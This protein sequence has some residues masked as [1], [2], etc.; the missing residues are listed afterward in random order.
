IPGGQPGLAARVTRM[1][2]V[3]PLLADPELALVRNFGVVAH[4]DAGKTTLC[5]RM[6]V[7]TGVESRLGEVEEG[8]AVL[9][10]M[11]EERERGISITA[12]ATTLPWREH[13]LHLIDTPGHVDF[14]L[15]VERSLRVLDGAIVVFDVL[16]G[17]Q[18]QSEAVWRQMRRHHAAAVAFVNKLDRPG[19]DFLAA[20]RGI[21]ERLGVRC[22]PV[23]YPGFVDGKLVL[24]AD[25]VRGFAYV[26]HRAG[27]TPERIALP[28]AIAAEVGVL[29]A[30]LAEMLA[31]EDEQVFQCV[32]SDREPAAELLIAALR[33][34]T[35]EGSLL[36][37]ACGS[38]LHGIGVDAALDLV[39]D[40]LP[41]PVDRPPVRA[42]TVT[43]GSPPSEIRLVPRA[44]QPLVLFA[45]KLQRLARRDLVFTRVIRGVVALGA[46]LVV[47]RTGAKQKVEGLFRPHADSLEQIEFARPGDIVAVLGLDAAAT[48][49]TLCEPGVVCALEPIEI[50]EPVLSLAIEPVHARDRDALREGLV[51]LVREDPSLAL[52]EDETSGQWLLS[53]MGELHL[54]IALE[55]LRSQT[56]L[57]VVRTAPRVAYREVPLRRASAKS[58]IVRTFGAS[59]LV[60]AT[61]LAIEPAPEVAGVEIVFDERAPP[62]AAYQPAILATLSSLVA[63][64]PKSGNPL[65]HARIVLRDEK[66]DGESDSE[67][68]VLQ[69][70]GSAWHELSEQLDVELH[71]P[72]MSFEVLTPSE[73]A[74]GVLGDLQSRGAALSEVQ[75]EGLATRIRGLVPLCGMFGYASAVRSLSQGRAGF[76]MRPAGTRP[77]PESEWRSRGLVLD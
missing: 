49:D 26:T 64:G 5:E 77:V 61:E 48:G 60:G 39:I 19:A 1:P 70:V 76:S 14:T 4:I 30:E 18:A 9:D 38:A 58:R 24:F 40:Y 51:R 7:R 69:A 11:P 56:S 36:P 46:E 3:D 75:S 54:E 45:F 13:Q 25:I 55:R 32:A 66:R 74:G 23:T 52:R 31:E 57:A 10:W 71:E 17:V 63:V 29:R 68:G 65:S 28:E 41:S 42:T 16:A 43:A 20:L 33:K 12:A 44:D 21:A 59:T 72:W 35:L 34:R 22:A 37:V 15:E 67:A 27:E 47:A 73:Y 2:S 8:T 6:L 53:G 50:P 62:L